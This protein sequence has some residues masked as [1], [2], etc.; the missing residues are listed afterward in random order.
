MWGSVH[1]GQSLHGLHNT[2]SLGTPAFDKNRSMVSSLRTKSRS[3]WQEIRQ[4]LSFFDLV[5][6]CRYLAVID[7]QK[8]DD[9]FRKNSNNLRLLFQHRFGNQTSF[10]KNN[11]TNLSDYKI[12]SQTSVQRAACRPKGQVKRLGSCLLW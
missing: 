9:N 2:R 11:I 10:Q 3:L 8:E 5:R 6:F 12:K 1:Y 7:E 4:F